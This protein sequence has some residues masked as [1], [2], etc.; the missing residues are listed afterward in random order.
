MNS[1]PSFDDDNTLKLNLP[2]NDQCYQYEN[3]M[4][5]NPMPPRPIQ[6]RQQSNQPLTTTL[7][8]QLSAVPPPPGAVDPM[9]DYSMQ[10]SLHYLIFSNQVAMNLAG[11][12]NHSMYQLDDQLLTDLVHEY[13]M[14]PVPLGDLIYQ[15]HDYELTALVELLPLV[16]APPPQLLLQMSQA[17]S[18]P[19]LVES[20]FTHPLYVHQAAADYQM[21][22][23]EGQLM[24]AGELPPFTPTVNDYEFGAHPF[25]HEHHA[26]H[27]HQHHHHHQHQQPPLQTEQEIPP[28]A[29]PQ[30]TFTH[31]QPLPVN[32]PPPRGA[33]TTPPSQRISK[34]HSSLRLNVLST[35]KN[36]VVST[37]TPLSTELLPGF[38]VSPL[39]NKYRGLDIHQQQLPLQPSLTGLHL[40]LNALSVASLYEAPPMPPQQLGGMMPP[41]NVFRQDLELSL[42]L[43]AGLYYDLLATQGVAQA[44]GAMTPPLTLTPP[45]RKFLSLSEVL[46]QKVKNLS[47]KQQE[48]VGML[49]PSSLPPLIPVPP[50]PM[51]ANPNPAPVTASS[52]VM[53]PTAPA[54]PPPIMM[55]ANNS[56]S[57]VLSNGLTGLDLG[58]AVNQAIMSSG[59][60]T[61]KHTRRRLLPRLKNGCWI[62]RIKHLKCDELRP[63]CSLCA[64]FGIDCDYLSEKPDYVTDK[65]LRR[66][67]LTSIS[68]LRKQK[69][70]QTP[71]KPKRKEPAPYTDV[72]VDPVQGYF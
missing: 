8:A 42:L 64:R 67:K 21:N 41:M 30:G 12:L 1:P 6:G 56:L 55:H 26:Q 35:K 36:L 13:L 49:G 71:A 44:S 70:L 57:L 17:A 53:T 60:K 27:Y 4:P 33:H 47:R 9:H 20:H 59:G 11:S 69:Q 28:N 22:H 62:C 10:N 51:G 46:A 63:L 24:P 3:S 19:L 15:I 29:P 39:C 5:F 31:H 32:P 40:V 18:A 65:E 72:A 7:P 61:K 68:A 2:F 66:E 16:P 37:L 54:A 23:P 43:A 38:G 45:R 58:A 34:K 52:L 25:P 50:A 48:S 14:N